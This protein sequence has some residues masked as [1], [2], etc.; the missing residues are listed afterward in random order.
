MSIKEIWNKQND[1]QNVDWF[2]F[3]DDILVQAIEHPEAINQNYYS[4]H[5]FGR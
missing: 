2:C 1:K 3:A 4:G 5:D